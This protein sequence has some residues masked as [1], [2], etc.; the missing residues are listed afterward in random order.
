MIVMVSLRVGF[1]LCRQTLQ[2]SFLFYRLGLFVFIVFAFFLG[3]ERILGVVML[4]IVG[5]FEFGFVVPEY[6]CLPL[7]SSSNFF[8]SFCISFLH[9]VTKPLIA[10]MSWLLFSRRFF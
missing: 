8:T 1:R 3:G 5:A 9:C 2:K 6:P 7:N 4:T 10:S